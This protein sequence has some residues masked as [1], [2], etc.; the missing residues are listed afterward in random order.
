MNAMKFNQETNDKLIISIFY[1]FYEEVHCD[2]SV[3]EGTSVPEKT[4]I[5]SHSTS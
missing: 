5:R 1:I 4:I 3:C 2:G